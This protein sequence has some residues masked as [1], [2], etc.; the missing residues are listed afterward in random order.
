[1]H[2]NCLIIDDERPLAESTALVFDAEGCRQFLRDNSSDLI[3]LDINLDQTSGFEL[4]RELRMSTQIPILFIS[5]RQSDD[6]TLL[7]LGLGGGG[8][9][10]SASPI[11]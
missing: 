8:T 11:P 5:A 4:C 10:I 3:L 6:D 7:A 9:I 1:M 2:Y